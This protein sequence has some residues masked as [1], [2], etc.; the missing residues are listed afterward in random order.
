[1]ARSTWDLYVKTGG[2]WVKDYDLPRPNDDFDAIKRSPQREVE[3]AEG[4]KA[5]FTPTNKYN[6]QGIRFVWYGDNGDIESHID[7]YITN[8]KDIKITDDKSNDWVGRFIEFKSTRVVGL[9]E[10]EYDLMAIFTVMPGLA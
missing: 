9:S 2:S 8:R 3:L 7:D 6:F 10:S 4:D 5:F 1:M